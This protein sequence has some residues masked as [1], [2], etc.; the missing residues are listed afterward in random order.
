M[1]I[2]PFSNWLKLCPVRFRIEFRNTE[3]IQTVKVRRSTGHII[4]FRPSR[5]TFIWLISTYWIFIMF[6]HTWVF[7]SAQAPIPHTPPN[8]P[9]YSILLD[10]S[11]MLD[12]WKILVMW[13]FIPACEWTW[14]ESTVFLLGLRTPYLRWANLIWC[15]YRR[16]SKGKREEPKQ[17]VWRQS[18]IKET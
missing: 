18:K 10:Y 6:L 12:T 11:V 8:K 3:N 13:G 15:C 7:I 16:N 17:G 1:I 4:I 14:W 2:L 5:I 9:P